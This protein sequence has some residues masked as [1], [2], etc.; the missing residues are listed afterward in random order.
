M[1]LDSAY[2][3][4]PLCMLA[5]SLM[6]EVAHA[7]QEEGGKHRQAQASQA[8]SHVRRR[9]ITGPTHSAT[10]KQSVLASFRHSRT[11]GFLVRRR[12]VF[13]GG[14]AL[15]GWKDSRKSP[16]LLVFF[17]Y[18]SYASLLGSEVIALAGWLRRQLLAS[19][20]RTRWPVRIPHRCI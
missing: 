1:S 4:S 13:C 20:S 2:R 6:P 10:A 5:L 11:G 16:L 8:L 3:R 19:S 18:R 17:F 12:D 15:P 7:R 9:H 14:G